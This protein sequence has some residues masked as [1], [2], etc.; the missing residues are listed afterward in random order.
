MTFPGKALPEL[1]SP[2]QGAGPGFSGSCLSNRELRISSDSGALFTAQGMSCS[3]TRTMKLQSNAL[4]KQKA[5]PKAPDRGKC[6]AGPVLS[7][8][9]RL[10]KVGKG[11]KRLEKAALPAQEVF[12]PCVN[13]PCPAEKVFCIIPSL[14]APLHSFLAPSSRCPLQPHSC[15]FWAIL[16]GLNPFQFPT[17]A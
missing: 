3:Q 9:K 2:G 10:E 17:A 8:R 12:C 14:S 7:Q 1:I 13:C 16:G 11:W 5:P 6:G 4:A 15:F